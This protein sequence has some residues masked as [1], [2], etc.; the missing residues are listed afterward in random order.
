[1]YFDFKSGLWII[2]MLW[3]GRDGRSPIASSILN[4]DF[5]H[6]KKEKYCLFTG[7]PLYFLIILNGEKRNSFHESYLFSNDAD[8]S[9]QFPHSIEM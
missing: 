5:I 6:H 8:N 9:I 1:M 7:N 2:L 4:S 3:S